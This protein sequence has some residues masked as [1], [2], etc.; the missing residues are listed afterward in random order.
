MAM[1]DHDEVPGG[2]EDPRLTSL[3]DRLKAAHHVEKERT[4]PAGANAAFTGK[5]AAQ[6]NRVL[7]TLIGAPLGAML[8]GWLIDRWL[9]SAPRAM[10]VML[11][12]GIIS[13]FVQIWRI[14]QERPK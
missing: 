4:T 14:S 11:F 3:S 2:G 12:L 5:G 7:S 10:L 8:I 13:A 9:G 6:G 1:S